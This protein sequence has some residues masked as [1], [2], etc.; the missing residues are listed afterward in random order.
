VEH[1]AL[2]LIWT[3]DQLGKRERKRREVMD[4]IKNNKTKK[5]ERKRERDGEAKNG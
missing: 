2:G 5:G 3:S 4:K 1:R